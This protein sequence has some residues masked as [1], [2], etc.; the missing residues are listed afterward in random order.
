MNQSDSLSAY[1]KRVWLAVAAVTLVLALAG[2]LSWLLGGILLIFAGVLFGVFLNHLSRQ[3]AA[4]TG[5]GYGWAF[6]GVVIVLLA[7][8]V[9]TGYFMGSRISQQA[10]EFSQQFESAADQLYAR[11]QRQ[12]WMRWI[13]GGSGE[14]SGSLFT[15]GI[16]ARARSAIFT[17]VSA[18][19][20]LILV[21]FLGFYFALQPAK[22]SE[23][24]ARL[25]PPS[26]RPR[27]Y[28]VMDET[29]QTLWWWILGRL[30]AMALIGVGSALGL[31]MLN[32]PLPVTLGVIA[33]LLNFIPNLGP[34]IASVPPILFALQQ[35][36]ESALYVAG[37]Y[38]LLQFVESYFITP[39]IDQRQVS[40]PPALVLSAQLLLGMIAGFLG[41]VL[42]TPITAA[43]FVL[44]RELYV[45]DTLE[46]PR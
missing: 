3:I 42:A 46:Q 30:A 28:E 29:T 34:L 37:F 5:V 24:I 21:L 9:G 31:W 17:V 23:G 6:S 19:G 38:L 33:G 40:L 36:P 27:A 20:S 2:I 14:S 39:M 13:T 43:L 15:D 4:L 8:V 22:Y 26:A 18:F 12:G 16:I 44:V 35:G 1:T 11:L 41:L 45:K 10:A 7:I 25:W 32:I